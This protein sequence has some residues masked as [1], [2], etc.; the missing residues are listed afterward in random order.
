MG[1]RANALCS[2]THENPTA[3]RLLEPTTLRLCKALAALFWLDCAMPHN[4][5]LT[6]QHKAEFA[7]R[8]TTCGRRLTTARDDSRPTRKVS[9]HMTQ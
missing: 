5:P 8:L 3:L 9:W 1:H 6:V 4:T 2:Q 7:G